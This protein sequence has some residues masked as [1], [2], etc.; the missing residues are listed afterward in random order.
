M[1]GGGQAGAESAEP[2]R[3]CLLLV[4]G[5]HVSPD[6]Q[7][8][9]SRLETRSSPP[10]R[11]TQARALRPAPPEIV[12][13]PLRARAAARQNAPAP[14]GKWAHS[15]AVSTRARGA[16]LCFWNPLP[17]V[18]KEGERGRQK[19][20]GGRYGD[21]VRESE[22]RHGIPMCPVGTV[23]SWILS[24]LSCIHFVHVCAPAETPSYYPVMLVG[25]V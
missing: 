13:C 2:G 15:R 7:A 3:L 18:R 17:A 1:R 25:K 16:P 23:C 4:F 22:D 10:R 8:A 14:T 9:Q 5:P 21:G 20:G 11:G 24:A 12:V 6:G 19:G